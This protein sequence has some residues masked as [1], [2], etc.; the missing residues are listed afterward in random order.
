MITLLNMIKKET[1]VLLNDWFEID[2]ESKKLIL[3]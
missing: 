2:I 3:K 1:I